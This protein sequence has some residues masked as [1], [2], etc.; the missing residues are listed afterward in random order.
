MATYRL[1]FGRAEFRA[2]FAGVVVSV[3]GDQVARVA[4]SLLVFDRT[5]SPGWTAGVYALTYLPSILAGPLLS[6]LADR[7]PR[8]RVMVAADLLRAVLVA[9]MAVPGLP[10]GWVA[11]LLVSVQAAGAP[12][13]AARAATAAAVLPGDE[14]VL[15]KGVLDV[16]VQLAQVIGFATG[17]TLVATLGTGPALIADA[18][19]FVVSAAVV[20]AGIRARP[21][22]A[23]SDLSA[24]TRLGR[25]W[26][27]LRAGTVLV[28]RTP[29]LRS[30][31][32]LACVAGCYV[33]VEGLAAPYAASIGGSPQ[34]VGVLL[35]ASPAGTVLGMVLLARLPPP[36]RMRL[37]GPL[38]I[39]ASVPLVLCAARP[40]PV[41]TTVLWGLSGM[42][43]AYHLPA[44]AAFTLAVPDHRRAQAYGLAATALTTSQ[45]GGIALAGLAATAVSASTVLAA[46]GGLGV[47]TAWAAGAAWNRARRTPDPL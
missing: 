47:L 3:A 14:F 33:T 37:L 23:A 29:E 34:A 31:V 17:G 43:S 11:A 13:N 1:V 24:G 21:E 26:G 27:D 2:L 6:G 25:W 5:S 16:V 7:W 8:R 42:A 44:S 10:L 39:A 12:G 40:G 32:G 4:L 38:A 15:G 30:L 9:V 46:A 45:G 19:S 22:P 20:R 41:V 28:A 36:V 18:A 35:A